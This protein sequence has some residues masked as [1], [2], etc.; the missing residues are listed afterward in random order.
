MYVPFV[1]QGLNTHKREKLTTH[2]PPSSVRLVGSFTLR[3]DIVVLCFHILTKLSP[4]S[5]TMQVGYSTFWH[6]N[7]DLFLDNEQRALIFLTL[8]RTSVRW[9]MA[10]KIIRLPTSVSYEMWPARQQNCCRIPV[11]H[12]LALVSPLPQR[13]DAISQS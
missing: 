7:N 11:G 6:E 13:V 12:E 2:P 9:L 5:R 3:S 10:S 4:T 8:F 1:A